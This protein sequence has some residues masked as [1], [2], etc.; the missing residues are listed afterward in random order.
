MQGYATGSVPDYQMAA[1]CMA[2]LF[3]SMGDQEVADLTRAMIDS[4]ETLD[5]TGVS[6]PF[7]DKHSTG[8]VGD[9]VSIV[10][11]P[12]VA[13]C[14]ARIPMMSG[15]GLG[16]TGG[17]L[18]KL[19]SIPG[20]RT[21]M[22]IGRVKE[23]L[24]GNGY[25]MIGQ[26]ESLV[27]ADRLMYALRDV[28]AT[29]ESIPL[30]TASIMSKK[31]AEGAESLVLDVKC[32]TGAFM[33]NLE[34]AE[35]LADSLVRVGHGLGRRVAAVITD[36][37]APLGRTAGNFLEIRECIECLHGEGPADL[38]GLTIR[39]GGWMLF[40]SELAESVE[41][42]EGR[43]SEAIDSGAAWARFVENV[44]FQGGEAAAVVEP[45]SVAPAALVHQV[46]S[47]RRGAVL[48]IEARAVG[49]ACVLLGAGRATKEDDVLPGV[50]VRL[51][52]HLG[53]SVD[54]GE[55]LFEIHA[56]DSATCE[57]AVPAV[58]SAY[59]IGQS[60]VAPPARLIREVFGE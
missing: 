28:T 31:F 39:L 8:G 12:M 26:S 5:L 44:R 43:C 32:G 14:G 30:I 21:Q 15:R 17:T 46:I 35:S 57:Q 11:A 40:L 48:G 52:K 33:Q 2:V 59:R 47:D 56:V 60:R 37:N 16:H 38:T 58:L 18:D 54:L 23:G 34:E 53:D 10:L 42:G 7:V 25:V 51:L 29:V 20:Y 13:A 36:M 41:A 9:K 45:D 22:D 55:P 3:R 1:F 27:P 50:G 4:G 49:H 19:E 24:E 6:G